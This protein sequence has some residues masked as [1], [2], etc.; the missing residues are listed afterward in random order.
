M[1]PALHLM[2]RFLVRR[3]SRWDL[4]K[5]ALGVATGLNGFAVVRDARILVEEETGVKE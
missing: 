2:E 4:A 1:R 5:D 3:W